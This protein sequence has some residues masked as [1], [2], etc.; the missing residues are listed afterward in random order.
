MGEAE[1]GQCSQNRPFLDPIDSPCFCPI[2]TVC[3]HSNQKDPIKSE[4]WHIPLL[5]IPLPWPPFTQSKNQ[6]T[7]CGPECSQSDLPILSFELTPYHLPPWVFHSRLT[8]HLGVFWMCWEYHHFRA[9][10]LAVLLPW[11]FFPQIF[12]W[13]TPSLYSCLCSTVTSE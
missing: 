8:G 7:H 12:S 9:F 3:S 13:L 1:V 5:L 11:T 10:V 6:S 4:V 2:A